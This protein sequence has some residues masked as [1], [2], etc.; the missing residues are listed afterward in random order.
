MEDPLHIAN[1]FNNFFA[2]IGPRLAQTIQ[3]NGHKN[4]SSFLLQRVMFS[5]EFDVV[6]EDTVGKYI[7][8]LAPKTSC[9]YDDISTKLLKR[10]KDIILEYLTVIIN[11]SLMTGIFPDRL[12]I[13]KV[14]PLFKKDDP[15]ILDNYRPISLLPSISKVF[16]KVVFFQTYEYFNKNKLINYSQYGFRKLHST[17]LASLELTDSLLQHLDAGRIPISVFLDLSKAFDTL[18]HFILIEKLSYYGVS[19]SALRWFT[20]YLSNLQRFVDISGSKS[21]ILPLSTGVPQGSILGP[22]LFIIYM[23]DISVACSNFKAI[24]YADDTNLISSLCS[25]NTNVYPCD[26][27]P[28]DISNNINVELKAIQE[29][30][31]INKLSLNI[32]KTKFM[33]FHHPQRNIENIVPR[34]KFHDTEVERVS[35]F[36]FL[37]L[38]IDEHLSW[39]PH[40]DKISSKLSRTI[41][42]LNRLKRQ[43]PSYI[44]RM[45]Y[46]SLIL[47]FLQYSVLCWGYNVT[48]ITKLQKRAIRVITNA[49]YNAH[50]EPL[51]KKMNLLKFNDMFDICAL[52]IYYRLLDGSLPYYVQNIFT[53]DDRTRRYETRLQTELPYFYPKTSVAKKCIRFYLPRFI[54]ELSTNIKDKA[55]THSYD[56]FSRYA[57]NMAIN[58][59]SLDCTVNDCYVCHNQ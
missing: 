51:F 1:A 19:G 50:T 44:L 26:V 18:D 3:Y 56:G 8:K 37:G 9:G 32:K 4:V 45:L 53:L 31:L 36:N 20:S 13:A 6:T 21:D 59:Y 27:N 17:E 34:L 47:P 30:L 2:N 38:T 33:V 35:E 23:N 55:V 25:F 52:K 42:V 43:L 54:S 12:K 57:R 14:I 16:E 5:F 48:R 40:Q 22:L 7:D 11:Q 29:W 10:I 28:N 58:S 41:G 24:L 46:N 39:R 49:K 15:H